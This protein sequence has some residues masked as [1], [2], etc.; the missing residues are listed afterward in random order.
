[1]S[2]F[3]NLLVVVY[4]QQQSMLEAVCQ[5]VREELQSVV[6]EAGLTK[7]QTVSKPPFLEHTGFAS[8]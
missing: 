6:E 3:A 4:T 8:H 2:S 7:R 5:A 1:M